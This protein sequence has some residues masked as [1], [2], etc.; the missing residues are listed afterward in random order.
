MY[1][2]RSNWL[3]KRYK[4]YNWK[5]IRKEN[6]RKA[7]IGQEKDALADLNNALMYQ[8]EFWTEKSRVKLY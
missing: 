8:E 3:T 4:V 6:T 7:L 2:K 5:L 1:M